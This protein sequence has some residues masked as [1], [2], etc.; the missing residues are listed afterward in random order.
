MTEV[1]DQLPGVEA[2]LRRHGWASDPP[3]PA[4]AMWRQESSAED[5]GQA[6]N[7]VAVPRQIL[8]GTIEWRSVVE[9][10]AAFERI[11]VDQIETAIR[12]QFIDVT[13]LRVLNDIGVVGS[14]SLSA[15]ASMITAGRVM[16]RAAATT[17]FGPKAH[18]NGSFS[19]PADEIAK[20][21]RLGHTREGSYVIPL[22]MPIPPQVSDLDDH[23]SLD[24][25]TERVPYEPAERRVTRTLAQAL[26]AVQRGIVQPAVAPKV[27]DVVPLIA[28]GVSRELVVAVDEV[29]ADDNI[30]SFA[31]SFGWAEAIAPPG[32][33]PSRVE[34]PA[35]ASG[36]L[37][38]TATLL[39]NPRRSPS[40][41]ITGPIVEV[42]HLPGDPF[43]EIAVQTVRRGRMNEIRVRLQGKELNQALEWMRS[44]RAVL[45]EGVI[46]SYPGHPLRIEKASRLAPLDET[47]LPSA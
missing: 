1:R 45:V 2:Y 33:V 28:A 4:G 27:R 38:A 5:T 39:K 36:L 20:R 6:S 16:V 19:K 9:R 32:G 8:P 23:P 17:A 46:V 30:G 14:V 31:A 13:Q 26:Q 44:A 22:L 11:P 37:Q 40:Q 41:V 10:L 25:D 34:I 12:F 47:I 42:R 7:V 15:G 21:V 35:E 3:G 18:I 24:I 43:G 29:L